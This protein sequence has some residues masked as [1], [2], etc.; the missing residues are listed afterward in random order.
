MAPLQARTRG[1]RG[2]AVS[3]RLPHHQHGR[4]PRRSERCHELRREVPGERARLRRARAA[5]PLSRLIR[6]ARRC[7][8][9]PRRPPP[10]RSPCGAS[11]APVRPS[12][13]AIS[14][15]SNG[16]PSISPRI[17]TAARA[18]ERRRVV[19]HDARPRTWVVALLK[20][21]VEFSQHGRDSPRTTELIAGGARCAGGIEVAGHRLRGGGGDCGPHP[22]AGARAAP[23]R[24]HRPRARDVRPWW[25]P[26]RWNSAP[27][28]VET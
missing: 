7:G 15:P 6:S 16:S 28:A 3:R 11:W 10:C 27:E 25:P 4:T 21:G 22:G 2:A 9:G 23:P 12:P 19:H 8:H 20:W 17:F 26:P 1:N 18:E 5:T 13:C 14:A 24:R